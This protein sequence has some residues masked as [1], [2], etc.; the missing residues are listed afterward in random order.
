MT[1]KRIQ[2]DRSEGIGMHFP[3]RESSCD[4][5]HPRWYDWIVNTDHVCEPDDHV[6]PLPTERHRRVPD[7]LPTNDELK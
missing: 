2:V 6:D 7:N 4:G 3:E 1:I 5:A